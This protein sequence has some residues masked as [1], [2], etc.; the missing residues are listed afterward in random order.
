MKNLL[1]LSVMLAVPVQA[2]A[3]SLTSAATTNPQNTIAIP[4]NTEYA[5]QAVNVPVKPLT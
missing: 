5:A 2:S 4:T 1:A 3:Q